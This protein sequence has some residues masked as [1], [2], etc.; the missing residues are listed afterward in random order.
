MSGHMEVSSQAVIK[1]SGVS[2]CDHSWKLFPTWHQYW[3]APSV[4]QLLHLQV[5]LPSDYR[6]FLSVCSVAGFKS[7]VKWSS[8]VSVFQTNTNLSIIYTDII[9]KIV[10]QIRDRYYEIELQLNIPNKINIV[11]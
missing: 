6:D 5:A 7:H 9:Q 1:L 4:F 11:L 10:I 2:V 3:V 8:C